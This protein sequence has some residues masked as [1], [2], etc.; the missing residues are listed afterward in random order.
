MSKPQV[1]DYYATVL[2]QY[3]QLK[4]ELEVLE[5]ASILKNVTKEC[6]QRFQN[7]ERPSLC[8]PMKILTKY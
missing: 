4:G 3:A 1:R 7:L 6:Y 8:L 2:T 5:K